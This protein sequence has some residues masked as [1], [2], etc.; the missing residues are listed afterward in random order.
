[1]R[2]YEQLGQTFVWFFSNKRERAE[3]FENYCSFFLTAMTLDVLVQ[4]R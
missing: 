2:C 1:M 4:N 3:K